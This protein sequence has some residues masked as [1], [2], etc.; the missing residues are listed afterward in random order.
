MEQSATAMKILTVCYEYPPIGGGGGNMARNIAAGLVRRGHEVRVQT[1][2]IAGLSKCE[3]VDGV[4]IRRSFAFRRRADF[5][6]V[7]EMGG[8]LA[9]AFLP[10]WRLASRWKP[11][12]IHAHFAVPS[13]ALAFAVS[14][15]TRIPYLVTVHLGDL[16]GGNPDQTDH[17]FRVLDPL[18]RPIWRNASAVSASSIFAAN[19]ARAAYGITPEIIHNGISMDG[20]PSAV[21]PV[22]EKLRLVAIGRFNPQKNFP[23]MIRMLA[24]CRFPWSLDLIGDGSQVGEVRDAIGSSHLGDRIRLHG[25]LPEAAMRETLAASDILLMP[26][27]SEGNPVAAIEA[28]KQGVAILG[29]DAPGLND[30][31]ENNGNGYAVSLDSPGLYRSKLE[32]LATNRE[33][34]TAMKR[35]S[36]ELSERFDIER[37]S[38]EFERLLQ[39][40]ASCRS[41]LRSES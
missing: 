18:I 40:V 19:L 29:S 11:D 23:W 37:I 9:G 20:R 13:G 38:A 5:C 1:A 36:L 6:T 27:T 35:R 25:W 21:R 2:Y 22:G 32:E 10:T 4:M 14:K 8:Y 41:P 7:P 39:S 12:C 34:L 16:P 33:V 30:L 31:I 26:S 3:T 24:E 17:L 15:L 28:L